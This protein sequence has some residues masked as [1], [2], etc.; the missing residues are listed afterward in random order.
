MNV[1]VVGTGDMGRALVRALAPH[2]RVRWTGRS[3]DVTEGRLEELG[4]RGRVEAAELASA[5]DA[6][7]V[8]LALWHRH[9]REFAREYA[10]V[11]AGKVVVDIA[12]PFTED[13]E[14]FFLPYDTSAAE[15][16]QKLLPG[17]VVVG[18][19]KNT[20]VAVF[21]TPQFEEGA[22]DVLVTCDDVHARTLVSALLAPLPFRVLDAGLLR[23]NRVIERMT[24]LSREVGRRHGFTRRLSYRLLGASRS[25]R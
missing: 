24:L 5:L 7:V 12:N 22:S 23:N 16:L 14:D 21:D 9:A 8:V 25:D 6:D 19:F 1:T 11:L 10:E 3:V 17:S 2:H 20:F 18:A 15:E 13:F 4:L